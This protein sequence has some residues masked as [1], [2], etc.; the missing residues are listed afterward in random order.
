MEWKTWTKISAVIL[1]LLAITGFYLANFHHLGVVLSLEDFPQQ[2]ASLDSSK[3]I[4]FTFYIYNTG[5]ETAFIQSVYVQ[6]VSEESVQI[7]QRS[8]EV[9]P[10]G[11]FEIKEGESQQITVLLPTPGESTNFTLTAQVFYNDDQSIS[12]ETIPLVW[13]TLL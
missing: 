6:T 9:T 8:I 5:D 11:D 2:L 3:D 4:P 12:S 1:F 10:K 13:G 7:I